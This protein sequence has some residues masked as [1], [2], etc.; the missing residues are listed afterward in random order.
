MLNGSYRSIWWITMAEKSISGV[1]WMMWR[2]AKNE[3]QQKVVSGGNKQAFQSISFIFWTLNKVIQCI[4]STGDL[5]GR[6][7][8]DRFW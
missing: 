2:N 4:A 7:M 5:H 1:C 8:V 3:E 6:S